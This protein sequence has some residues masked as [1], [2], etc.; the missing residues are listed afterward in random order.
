MK[1]T[2]LMGL[3]SS[4]EPLLWALQSLLQWSHFINKPLACVARP[5]EKQPYK[6]HWLTIRSYFIHYN[7]F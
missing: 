7:I 1:E 3:L 6:I 4:R 2:C 5:Y